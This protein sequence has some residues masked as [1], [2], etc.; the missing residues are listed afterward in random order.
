MNTSRQAG[1]TLTELAVVMLIVS[2]LLSGVMFTLSAQTEERG[3]NQTLQRL[4]EAKELLLAFSLVNGRFPCPASNTSNGVES[5]SG[6]GACTDYYT[7]YL[8]GKAIA[9]QPT[10][11]SGYALDAWGNRI[12]YA[13]SSV[14]PSNHFTTA[15]S[16][17]T[18]GIT[19]APNDLVVCAAATGINTSPPSCGTATP[20][21]NQNLVAAVVWSQGKNYA[22]VGASGA[23]ETANNKHRL[24]SV[25]N[26]HAVFV[27][28]EPRPAGASGGEYDDLV[29]WIP[30]GAFYGRL[31]AAGVLP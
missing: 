16:L 7:G 4:E 15:T 19:T 11:S 23:D 20:V 2:L 18:N 22:V 28:H 31:I 25:L 5:P 24:P 8:P 13:V 10:D 1:F 26:N 3:R 9:F 17:K 29:V 12:R 6:G 30:V 27:W 21:G 14:G